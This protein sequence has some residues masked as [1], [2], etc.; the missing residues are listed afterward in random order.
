MFVKYD[1]RMI[2]SLDNLRM[3]RMNNS[4]N[5]PKYWHLE[6]QYADGSKIQTP[7]TI[8][9]HKVNDAFRSLKNNLKVI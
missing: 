5:D 1:D 6:F 9:F 8:E 2:I 3:M 7:S 4:P